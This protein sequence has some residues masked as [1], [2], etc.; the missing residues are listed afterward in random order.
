[1]AFAAVVMPEHVAEKA[2]SLVVAYLDKKTLYL[3]LEKDDKDYEPD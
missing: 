2:P 1:M 3:V